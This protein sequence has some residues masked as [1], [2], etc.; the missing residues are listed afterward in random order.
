MGFCADI[1]SA[2]SACRRRRRLA[3]LYTGTG[4]VVCLI[5]WS[6]PA[7]GQ[8]A[9]VYSA[10]FG[11]A[12][13]AEPCGPG[14]FKEPAWIAVNE[15]TGNVYVV[16]RGND[17]IQEF[18]ATGT[19]HLT[20]FNGSTAPTGVFSSPGAV[21]VD[22][23][24]SA[25]DPSAGDVY[26]ADVGH[27]VIDK[28]S[29]T[30][31]YIDQLTTGAEGAPFGEI[32]GLAVD[33][34]GELWV[35]QASEVIENFGDALV[36]EY[37]A[38][39]QDP[40]GT[41]PGFAVDSKHD[42][43]V[44]RGVEEI[45][46]L[47]ESGQELRAAV[48]PER[49]TAVAVE[50]ATNDAY[51]DN[52]TTIG[53]FAPDGSLIERFGSPQLSGGGGLAVN[54][55]TGD[56]YVA[57]AALNKVDLFSPEPP[58]APVVQSASSS[59]VTATGAALEAQID[60]HGE[61]TA[62]HFEYGPTAAYGTRAPASDAGIGAS[63]EGQSVAVRLQG[64]T[65][66][67]SYHY[68]VLATNGHG[69]T[70]S[71]DHVFTTRP[72]AAPPLPDGRA[73]E[74]VSPVDKHGAALESMPYEGGLIQSSE[75]GGAIAYL[76]RAPVA[77]GAGGNA[78]EL[79][80]V[81][82][83]RGSGGVWSTQD[84]EARDE[85]VNGENS[86]RGNEYRFFSADL[87]RALIEQAG[88]DETPLA[89][90]VTERTMYLRDNEAG[91][92]SPLVSAENV[93]PGTKYGIP[94][95]AESFVGATPDLS[96]VV[97]SARTALTSTPI[98][99]EALYEWA[100][101]VLQLVSV[102]PDGNPG[103]PA[104]LGDEG[105]DVRRAISSDGSRIFWTRMKGETEKHLYLRDLRRGQTL[106]IDAVEGA[107]ESAEG[108]ATFQTASAD[109]SR[110][111]FADGQKLTPDSTAEGSGKRDLYECEVV[112]VSGRLAC[113]LR[114][115]TVDHHAGESAAV[116]GLVLGASDDGS[117][118]YFVANGALAPG[119]TEGQC[120]E[121]LPGTHGVTCNLY[122]WHEGRITFIAALSNEDLPGWRDERGNLGD[123]AS[124]VAPEG[125]Y[126]A[127]MSNR[128]LTGYDNTD[129][130]S[131]QP[132][133]EVYL[134]D[135]LSKRLVCASCNPTGA[136]P[137]GVFDSGEAHAQLLV[138]RR[139]VWTG[140]WLGGSIPAWTPIDGRFADYQ[141]RFLSDSGRLFFNSPDVLS[142][143]DTNG[144]ED[145][146]EYEPL[147]IGG[148]DASSTTFS[149][150]LA[151]CVGLISSG[152]S[153]EES[154][155]LDASVSG[156]DAFFLTASRLVP[157]DVDSSLDVYDAHVCSAETP[158]PPS[159]SSSSR[160]DHES[161][162]AA[163]SPQ[164]PE[165]FAAPPSAGLLGG[166]NMPPSPAPPATT[167]MGQRGGLTTALKACSRRPRRL[168][169]ACRR[170]ARKRYAGGSRLP[171]SARAP[172]SRARK[173]RGR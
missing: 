84:I 42:L 171:A 73:W 61:T 107:P 96:H 165:M 45:G 76:A 102:L 109:G 112:E 72:S 66:G 119:A 170:R 152:T 3:A 148:C 12:C 43:Y 87:S 81:L 21:A 68:R 70:P 39:R 161:C 16:D 115:L 82:S 103:A 78:W 113:D 106:Q 71:A 140:H 143:Q 138:D 129:V 77:T 99:G 131:G 142:S 128:S 26:V 58:G 127:F 88:Y 50:S 13:L 53:R 130:H 154:A 150:S 141:S 111:F 93:L 132:D 27:G 151:G 2:V 121:T 34:A 95:G 4:T 118:V 159:H 8:R 48:D 149:A 49:S 10:A 51:V 92:Y 124:R 11:E 40:F 62:Y 20:D 136:R 63:F 37:L 144:K 57:D 44:N 101:G 7:L 19:T 33:A 147:G 22:N 168:R 25:G 162:R 155:F 173:G 9:H 104:Q 126:L 54:S 172:G 105:R 67:A 74:L 6:S 52:V 114:D 145:V 135:A 83:K 116:R 163:P 89:P 18:N 24:A 31:G 80:Q 160:C 47:S 5:A 38:R 110:V 15:S 36:N 79:S 153:S 100:G 65:P 41:S 98:N 120:A 46:E 90:G 91:G 17:R 134:F 60:P 32:Y 133:E 122:L 23:S 75:D 69:V 86:G 35:Y 85:A 125:R 146:Y 55:A 156:E 64:L 158:C 123:V 94:F 139:T 108:E 166:G 56:V 157:Q 164:P 1:Q 59:S 30:G 97:F 28:F 14:Q 29:A 137:A 169:S 117:Y 167:P